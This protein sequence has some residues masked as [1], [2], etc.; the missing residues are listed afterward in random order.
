MNP[1]IK[2]IIFAAIVISVN[3]FVLFYAIQNKG[4]H[5][6]IHSVGLMIFLISLVEIVAIGIYG[7]IHL[8]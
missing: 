4:V 5:S 7:Y 3:N 6:K 8:K 2:L 1:A